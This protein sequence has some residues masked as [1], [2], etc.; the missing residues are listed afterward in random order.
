MESSQPY[1]L[2]WLDE[3]HKLDKTD[4]KIELKGISQFFCNKIIITL[5]SYSVHILILP[6]TKLE[7]GLWKIT[8][9]HTLKTSK[10]AS[11][12]SGTLL[13][14]SLARSSSAGLLASGGSGEDFSTRQT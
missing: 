11:A 8:H 12:V 6:A 3:A 2:L 4:G 5:F 7:S 1:F 10:I 13:L 14:H 9:S